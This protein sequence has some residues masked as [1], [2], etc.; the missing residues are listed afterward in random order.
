MPNILILKFPYSSL[1][2]GGEKHTI[3][4]VER[5]QKKGYN[6]WLVSS[7]SVLLAEYKKRKWNVE[8]TWSVTEQVSPLAL[9]AFMFLWPCILTILLIILFKY[10]Y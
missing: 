6:V 8:T 7:C 2:G 3:T 5:L 9:L 10:N 4:L 1:Y